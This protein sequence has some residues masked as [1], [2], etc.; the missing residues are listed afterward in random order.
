MD[1]KY[2]NRVPQIKCLRDYRTTEQQN[3]QT[4]L[5]FKVALIVYI[6][7]QKIT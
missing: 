2:G 1:L 7:K 6:W 5:G 4:A 3:W